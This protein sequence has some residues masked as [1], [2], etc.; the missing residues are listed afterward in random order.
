MSLAM[1]R[2]PTSQICI[3]LFM[4]IDTKPHLESFCRNPIHILDLSVAFFAFEV[5]F[6]VPL[7]VEQNMFRKIES[8]LPWCRG[9]GVKIFVFLLNPRMIGNDIIVT[10]EAFFNRRQPRMDRPSHIRVAELALNRLDT[11]MDPVTERNGLFRAD[12]C[13]RRG[14]KKIEKTKNQKD[15]ES[16]PEQRHPVL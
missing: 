3:V 15:T 8:L 13:R 6:D 7:V 14:I 12:T 2:Q 10:I 11:G 5:S 1:A 9:L 4:T 16:A